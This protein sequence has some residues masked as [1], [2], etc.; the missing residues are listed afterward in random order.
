MI[1]SLGVLLVLCLSVNVFAAEKKC[2]N[3]A[4]G[5]EIF[6]GHYLTDFNPHGLGNAFFQFG[7][8]SLEKEGRGRVFETEMNVRFDATTGYS[9]GTC[10]LRLPFVKNL[11]GE[12][13]EFACRYRLDTPC[14]VKG[15]Q[16]LCAQENQAKKEYKRHMLVLAIDGGAN[17][18]MKVI[19]R[20]RRH[21]GVRKGIDFDDILS[22]V[23]CGLGIDYCV[24]IE[25]GNL[26]KNELG[27]GWRVTSEDGYAI[28]WNLKKSPLF[29]KKGAFCTEDFPRGVHKVK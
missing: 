17:A 25:F 1:R 21:A 10:T 22:N 15:E 18:E 26:Y 7:T 14:V 27:G 9:S 29:A 13:A 6:L 16:I 3:V 20:L 19:N 11:V 28:S 8:M 23:R 5:D 24:D 2:F 4:N 12:S